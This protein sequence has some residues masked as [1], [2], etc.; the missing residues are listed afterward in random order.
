[1]DWLQFGVGVLWWA[2]A[3]LSFK[4]RHRLSAARRGTAKGMTASG[5]TT[6]AAVWLVFGTLLVIESILG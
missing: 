3:L 5:Y 1:M 2:L 6:I 4:N